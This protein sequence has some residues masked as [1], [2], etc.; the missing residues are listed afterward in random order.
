MN[1]LTYLAGLFDGEGSVSISLMKRGNYPKRYARLTMSICNCN[2]GILNW[3]QEHF[4]GSIH[5]ISRDARYKLSGKVVWGDAASVALL[6]RLHPF[7]MIKKEQATLAIKFQ[8][9][10]AKPNARRAGCSKRVHRVRASLIRRM[11][12]LNRR[13]R[14]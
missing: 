5:W 8:A 12:S 1:K 11:K 3:I 14:A 7:L 2:A 10:K 4:G 9:T 6:R 13:G